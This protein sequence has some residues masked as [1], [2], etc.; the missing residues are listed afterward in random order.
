MM[1]W[2]LCYPLLKV[3]SSVPAAPII[4][5]PLTTPIT[6]NT[7]VTNIQQSFAVGGNRSVIDITTIP[8]FSKQQKRQSLKATTLKLLTAKEQIL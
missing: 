2:K 8:T 5:V 1:E 3:N 6:G 7:V 4:W